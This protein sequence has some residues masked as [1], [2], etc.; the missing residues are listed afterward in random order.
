MRL[1]LDTHI[2]LWY[3][4]GDSRVGLDMRRLIEDSEVAY[5][6]V[7]SVWEATIKYRIG[8]L[9]LPAPPHPWLVVQREQHGI[10][11]LP[12]DEAAV[13]HLSQLE[14]HHRDPFDRILV[15]QAIQHD[16][17]IVTV[18]R[19]FSSYAAKLLRPA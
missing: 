17:Q 8:K 12:I 11:S 14:L 6:S 13:T 5:L 10:E 4:T 18:D 2:F 1:L 3:I 7:A 16:L 15:S 9:P 19:I